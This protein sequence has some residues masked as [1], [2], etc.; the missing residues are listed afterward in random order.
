MKI[1]VKKPKNS[2]LSYFILSSKKS[3]FEDSFAIQ[4]FQKYFCFYGQ[5]LWIN[6]WFQ[7]PKIKFRYLKSPLKYFRV[8]RAQ[9]GLK[10]RL[11][12]VI[13]K[14]CDFLKALIVILWCHLLHYQKPIVGFWSVMTTDPK[15]QFK[16]VFFYYAWLLISLLGNA[17]GGDL[18]A[19]LKKHLSEIKHTWV[20]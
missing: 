3:N 15:V 17:A 12:W 2:V 10:M 7:V 8:T 5:V 13:S 20:V 11:F 6:F 4:N 1:L 19:K 16:A 18:G 9:L 14:H